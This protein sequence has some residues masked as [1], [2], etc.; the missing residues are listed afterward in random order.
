MALR[1]ESD[2]T[3]VVI[4]ETKVLKYVVLILLEQ[5]YWKNMLWIKYWRLSKVKGIETIG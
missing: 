4:L 3:H 5:M 1:N 2:I